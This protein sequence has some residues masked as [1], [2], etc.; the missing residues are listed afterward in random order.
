MTWLLYEGLR[1]PEKDTA[2]EGA[3]PLQTCVVKHFTPLFK[4]ICHLYV[5][6]QAPFS[7]VSPLTDIHDDL[8]L[9]EWTCMMIVPMLNF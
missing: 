6:R 4:R 1:D 8:A 3:T 5:K 7:L 2:L 9:D